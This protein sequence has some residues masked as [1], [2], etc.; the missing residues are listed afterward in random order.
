MTLAN[1]IEKLELEDLTPQLALGP[2]TELTA[3]YVSALLSDVL[4]NAPSG[5]V[6][7]TVQVHLNA[8]AVA[9]HAE[10]AA[11]VFAA[12]RRPDSEVRD[13]AVAEGIRLFAS[14]DAAFD[15]VGKLYALGLR[16]RTG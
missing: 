15:L 6:L 13:R 12:G 14:R 3:G 11:V 9:V 4:A 16:G 8:V 2:A 10:L 1:F 5:G 7:V